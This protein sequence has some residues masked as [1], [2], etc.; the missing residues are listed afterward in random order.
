MTDTEDA[1]MEPMAPLTKDAEPEWQLLLKI[2]LL[3]FSLGVGVGVFVMF[4]FVAR[5]LN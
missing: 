5:N 2:V 4:Y 3:A 1:A